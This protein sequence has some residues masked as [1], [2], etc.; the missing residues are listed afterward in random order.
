MSDTLLK[1]ELAERLALQFPKMPSEEV[2]QVVN[3][4]LDYMVFCMAHD[5]RIEL[6]GFGSFNLTTLPP[7]VGRNPSTGDTVC[8]GERR[9]V[10]FR[11]G[12]EMRERINKNK[13]R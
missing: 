4:L 7:K 3:S 2:T 11:P 8:L 1:S 6:R 10:R 13:T 5:Y 9:T 12:K